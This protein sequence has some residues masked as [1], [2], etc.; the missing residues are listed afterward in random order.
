MENTY[1]VKTKDKSTQTENGSDDNTL[2]ETPD[3][4]TWDNPLHHSQQPTVTQSVKK[5]QYETS[6]VS[7]PSI[8]L[9]SA[10]GNK[11]NEELLRKY[12]ERERKQDR[13]NMSIFW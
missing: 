1:V 2:L 8:Q 13:A 12:R 10:K 3:M 6:A 7:T 4:A 9:F 5:K 11:E